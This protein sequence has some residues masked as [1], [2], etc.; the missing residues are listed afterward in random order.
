[1]SK[2]GP[3]TSFGITSI[4]MAIVGLGVGLVMQ[5][6]VVA[7]QNSVPYSQLGTAT[8]TATFFRTIGGSFGVSGLGVVF[9]NRLLSNL[10]AHAAAAQLR[11]LSGSSV[12]ANPAQID[13]FPP[14]VRVV[15]VNAFSHAL[16]GV[17]L[18]AVPFAVL[19]FAL[20][21]IMKEIPLRTTAHLGGP[22]L[23]EKDA[24]IDAGSELA[25]F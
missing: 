8:S 25:A 11:G 18:V 24:G 6:L 14:A 5:V 12:T 7:V 2:L 15:F 16:Q 22:G 23:D 3:H 10:K 21:F 17:F 20:S 19:A 9:N 1:L 13:H 4:Y